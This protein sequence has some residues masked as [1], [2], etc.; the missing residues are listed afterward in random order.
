[1]LAPILAACKAEHDAGTLTDH[2]FVGVFLLC[3]MAIRRPDQA[4][5]SPNRNFGFFWC[6]T[7][8]ASKSLRPLTRRFDFYHSFHPQKCIPSCDYFLP[9]SRK[10]SITAHQSHNGWRLARCVGRGPPGNA[11]RRPRILADPR[12][13][14]R[15]DGAA[16][17]G[18]P[19][20]EAQAT[21]K[22][23]EPDT[24][25]ICT[26]SPPPNRIAF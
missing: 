6:L 22:H 24:T 18:I 13:D 11:L 3:Y 16:G 15:A 21:S 8:Q 2:D 19:R 1:M 4:P 10:G 12:V 14:P 25:I 9:Q 5:P 7:A 26:A 17:G 23:P 20:A